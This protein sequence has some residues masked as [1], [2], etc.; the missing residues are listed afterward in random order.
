MASN[1]EFIV[2]IELGSSKITG[3]AGKKNLD[4]SISIIGMQ[5]EESSSFIR[6]GVVYKMDKTAQCISSIVTKLQAQLKTQITRV[7]VGVG[8]QSIHSEKNV[9]VRD[10]PMM[11]VI[12]NQMIDDIQETNRM[13][14]YPQQYILDSI[15]EEY[16]VDNLQQIDPVGIQC[17]HLEANFINILYR[18]QFYHNLNECFQIAGVQIAEMF[19]SPIALA[20]SVL[21]DAEKRSGCV[22]V[23]LG[24]DTTTVAIYHKN[25]LRH[26]AVIPLGGINITRDIASQ[27]IE[28]DVAEMMKKRYGSAYSDF[29]ETSDAVN[30]NAGEDKVISNVLFNEIVESR[31]REIIENVY[32]Q[33]P[34]AYRENLL[35]GLIL[36]GGGCNMCDIEKAF[37]TY[38]G[39][40]KVRIAKFVQQSINSHLEDIRTD[41]ASL[42]TALSILAK[43]DMNCSGEDYNPN[44]QL[45]DKTGQAAVDVSTPFVVEQPQQAKREG[46]VITPAEQEALDRKKAEEE[47]R[48]AEEE[49]RLAAEAA[50]KEEEKKKQEEALEKQNFLKEEEEKKRQQSS[51][52]GKFTKWLKN[53]TSEE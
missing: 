1:K 27:H 15:T 36:T 21:S 41:D 5:Q 22:L 14:N 6:N 37:V 35:G 47:A 51:P 45:F 7:Y 31:M 10:L 24:A 18:E 46:V 52:F 30:Y 9:I 19:L 8:G 50:A 20:D 42:N 11:E 29:I 32:A 3:I 4:G 40:Q 53:L 39:F 48:Q 12:T 2:A 23:D 49:A 44:S 43:G 38:T 34:K 13:M 33:V 26:L 16:K 17:R 28:E 25:I